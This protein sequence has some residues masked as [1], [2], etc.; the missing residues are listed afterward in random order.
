MA[1]CPSGADSSEETTAAPGSEQ[2][3][4]L[5]KGRRVTN[6][7]DLSERKPMKCFMNSYFFI[8]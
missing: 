4:R 1:P 8:L 7:G 6:E 2:R 5:P 3:A